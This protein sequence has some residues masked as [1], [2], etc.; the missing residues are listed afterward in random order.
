M[1]GGG[2]GGGG[3]GPGQ[4][5]IFMYDFSQATTILMDLIGSSNLFTCLT[6]FPALI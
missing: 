3:G 2:G 1:L 6:D 5:V 4:D